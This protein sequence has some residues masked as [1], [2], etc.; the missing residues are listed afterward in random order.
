MSLCRGVNVTVLV[1]SES[2]SV[3]L[4]QAG[5][6]VLG[7]ANQHQHDGLDTP[8]PPEQTKLARFKMS[9]CALGSLCHYVAG[10]M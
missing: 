5:I 9:L 4:M 8:Y 1:P 7:L 3:F 6:S 10:R 2:I